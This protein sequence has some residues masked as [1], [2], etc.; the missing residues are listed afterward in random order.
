MYKV[1]KETLEATLQYLSTQPFNQV[2]K[3]IQ[4][5]QA[6]QPMDDGVKEEKLKSK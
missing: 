6:S 4:A 3:L 1:S 2:A 5:L